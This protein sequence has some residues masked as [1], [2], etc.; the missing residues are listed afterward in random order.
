MGTEQNQTKSSKW[1]HSIHGGR[2]KSHV[3][4]QKKQRHFYQNC[5][6][7]N[8]TVPHTIWINGT[9]IRNM[10]L[11]HQVRELAQTV[12]IVPGLQHYSLLSIDKCAEVNYIT[13]F[14][15]EEVTIFDGEK[16]NISSMQQSIIQGWRDPAT[17]LWRIQIEPKQTPLPPNIH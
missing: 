5:A 9:S 2:L 16:A 1:E 10:H 11:Q 12:D 7:L 3:E 15:P 4:L 17:G 14:T 13:V 6:T 8:K